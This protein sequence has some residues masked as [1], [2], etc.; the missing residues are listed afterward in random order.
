MVQNDCHPSRVDGNI[1]H[2]WSISPREA[3]GSFNSVGNDLSLVLI[4]QEYREL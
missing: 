1:V 3:F 4:L 2:L